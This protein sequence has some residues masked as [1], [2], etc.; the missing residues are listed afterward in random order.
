MTCA[1]LLQLWVLHSL[2]LSSSSH[3]SFY[4]LYFAWK[5]I[6]SLDDSYLLTGYEP[7]AYDLKETYV[8]SYTESLTHHSSPSKGSSGTRSTMTPHLRICFAKHTKYMSI[9]PSEQA[10][11]SVSRRRPYPSE[12]GDILTKGNF[13]RDEW[14]YLLYLFNISHFSSTD[15]SEVMSKRTQKDSGEERVSAKSRPMMN[16]VSR[17]SERSLDGPASTASESPV[18]PD[19]KVN[20]FWVRE[21]NSIKEQGDLLKT[22]THQA[23][24]NGMLIGLGLLNNRML[25]R[26]WKLEQGDLFIRT[27]H[28]QIH[29]WKR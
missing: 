14:N 12:R 22:I 11:L 19:M 4:L 8:E 10:G 16:F 24:Q 29:C 5:E 20:F 23:T 7:N 18:K 17:C 21:L 25:M 28:G 27:A 2:L 15:C 1:V 26:W 6:D 13:T 9:T 3:S